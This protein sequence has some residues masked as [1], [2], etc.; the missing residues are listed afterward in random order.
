MAPDPVD[1]LSDR[2]AL[3][4]GSW[5]SSAQQQMHKKQKQR[6]RERERERQILV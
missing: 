2:I 1:F 3:L 6:E 5:C 4:V